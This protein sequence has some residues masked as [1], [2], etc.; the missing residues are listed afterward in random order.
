MKKEQGITLITLI[1]YIILMTFV[2][3]GISVITSSF[4]GN[5]NNFDK[6]SEYAVS[7]AKFNMYFLND[8]KKS[9]VE[10]EGIGDNYIILSYETEY[11]DSSSDSND[12]SGIIISNKRKEYAEYSVQNGSLFREKV[13]ICDNVK[14]FSILSNGSEDTIKISMKIGSY[15]TTMTYAIEKDIEIKDTPNSGG[16]IIEI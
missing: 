4:Y 13:K 12:S 5:A 11:E 7:F 16:G 15:E 14:D 3:A 8:I 6:E 1:M 2:V 10:V 9:N